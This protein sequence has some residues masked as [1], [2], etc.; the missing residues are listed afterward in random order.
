[1]LK[2]GSQSQSINGYMNKE[3]YSALKKGREF[4]SPSVFT[5]ICIPVPNFIINSKTKKK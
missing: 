3:N 4:A 1:M 5:S 2:I